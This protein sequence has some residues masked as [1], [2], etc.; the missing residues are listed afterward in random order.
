MDSL[1]KSQLYQTK[2]MELQKATTRQ[3]TGGKRDMSGLGDLAV[4][5]ECLRS[6]SYDVYLNVALRVTWNGY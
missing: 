1:R 4:I 2:N 5:E 6:T 3:L